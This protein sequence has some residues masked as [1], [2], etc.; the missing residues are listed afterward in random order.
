MGGK[1]IELYV[2][3]SDLEVRRLLK[4]KEQ[5]RIVLLTDLT[6]ALKGSLDAAGLPAWT[7]TIE[8]MLEASTGAFPGGKIGFKAS[9]TISS[10]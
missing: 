4:D 10:K 2:V 5:D 1:K 3:P 6:K 8:V 9:L 7:A